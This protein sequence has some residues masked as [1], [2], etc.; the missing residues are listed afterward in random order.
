LGGKTLR[1]PGQNRGP[2][3]HGYSPI[4]HRACAESFPQNLRQR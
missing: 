2:L 4:R 1:R 3:A